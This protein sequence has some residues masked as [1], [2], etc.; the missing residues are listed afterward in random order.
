MQAKIKILLGVM[1]T[2][3][4]ALPLIS[5]AFAVEMYSENPDGEHNLSLREKIRLR[6]WLQHRRREV[7]KQFL[8]EAESLTIE[9]VVATHYGRILMVDA[10]GERLN[11]LIPELWSVDS[12]VINITEMFDGGYVNLGDSVT[13]DALQR[14]FTNE[15][16]VSIT[17]IVAYE[18]EIDNGGS[19]NH[20]YAVLPF[21]IEG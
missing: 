5:N 9:G 15:K 8:K 17:V 18:I 4:V 13:I 7:I 1:V 3:V 20:L 12:E 10:E 19:G 16:G 14:S 2:L 11:I 6:L 21:N